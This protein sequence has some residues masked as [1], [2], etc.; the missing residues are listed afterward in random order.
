MPHWGTHKSLGE[1]GETFVIQTDVLTFIW[2]E[3]MFTAS[4]K[5]D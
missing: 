3:F 4:V 1:P 2:Q 5:N